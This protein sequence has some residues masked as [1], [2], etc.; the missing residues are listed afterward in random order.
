MN[1]MTASN[2]WFS[3]KLCKASNKQKHGSN[4]QYEY[5]ESDPGFISLQEAAV[6]CSVANFD[7]SLPQEKIGAINNDI[8][9]TEQQKTQKVKDL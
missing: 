5:N 8:T 7:R 9:L 2:I 6:V 4:Y 1:K 3:G